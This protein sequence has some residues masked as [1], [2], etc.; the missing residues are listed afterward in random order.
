MDMGSTMCKK[1]QL[2]NALTED[3]CIYTIVLHACL[4]QKYLLEAKLVPAVKL[5]LSNHIVYNN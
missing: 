1:G 4:D 2:K 5:V 3:S